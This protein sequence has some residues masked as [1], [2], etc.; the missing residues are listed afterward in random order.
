[1]G[2]AGRLRRA[3]RNGRG[4][5]YPRDPRGDGSG[6]RDRETLRRLFPT[7]PRSARPHRVDRL[8]LPSGNVA[9]RTRRALRR[10]RRGRGP[11]VRSGGGEVPRSRVRP[12][13]DRRRSR[14]PVKPFPVFDATI[15]SHPER[16]QTS[17]VGEFALPTGSFKDRG[18]AAVVAA[19]IAAGARRVTLDS[20]GNAALAVA[21]AASRAGL[22]ALLRVAASI[23]PAKRALL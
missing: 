23:S 19:A 11:L 4:R 5:G 12:R 8:P 18:A 22:S 13:R 2:P 20:S 16:R 10:R 6:G 7:G 21:A 3:R 15:F 1:M 14:A 9:R 17:V